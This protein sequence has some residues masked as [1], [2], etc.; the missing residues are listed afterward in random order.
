[1][2]LSLNLRAY[3]LV[4]RAAARYMKKQ[5]GGSIVCIS[6]GNSQRYTTRR[7]PY[8]ITKAGINGLVGTLGSGV[9]PLQ[10]P[11]QRRGAGLCG[12]RAVPGSASKTASSM[13]T[14]IMLVVPMKRMLEAEEIANGVAF[15][16]S[17]EASGMTGQVLFIDGGWSR[18]GLPEKK[19]HV[20]GAPASGM[21]RA[22]GAAHTSLAWAALLGYRTRIKDNGGPGR[23]GDRHDGKRREA[24][25]QIIADDFGK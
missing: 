11:H 13:W 19:R 24:C 22:S 2:M 20:S 5:G 4:A 6:S 8:N 21:T 10:Y 14:T 1:M 16:A 12:Y 7:S 23:G 25:F 9:G 18:A 3:Y 15:L 17:E